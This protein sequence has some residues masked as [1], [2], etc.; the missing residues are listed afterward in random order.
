MAPAQGPFYDWFSVRENRSKDRPG[1]SSGE[2][3]ELGLFAQSYVPGTRHVSASNFH[4]PYST[5]T[6]S[7]R[8]GSEVHRGKKAAWTDSKLSLAAVSR[9][10]SESVAERFHAG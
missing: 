10:F 4:P 9:T 6:G 2:K 3:S 8:V 5:S 1:D 7:R